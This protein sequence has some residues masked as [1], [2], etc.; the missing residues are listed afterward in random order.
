MPGSHYGVLKP[1]RCPTLPMFFDGY[2]QLMIANSIPMEVKA[3]EKPL[4]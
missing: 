2:E 3:G 1:L 4:Y